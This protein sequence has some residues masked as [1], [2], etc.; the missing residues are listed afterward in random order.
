MSGIQQVVSA[1]GLGLHLILLVIGLRHQKFRTCLTFY[2]YLLAAFISTIVVHY[3][4]DERE[5][6]R[7]IYYLKEF[8]LDLIKL[9]M[10][11]DLNHRIF[12][13]FPKVRRL[14]RALF[15]TT[16]ILLLVYVIA[17][18][19][20]TKFWWGSIPFDLHSKIL[21]MTCLAYLMM[22]FSAL[23]Y[24]IDV[25]SEHKFLLMGYLLSQL[26]VALGFAYVAVAGEAARKPVSL[27]NSIFF[28][29]AL[30]VWTKVYW[31]HDKDSDSAD[32]IV[33]WVDN[34]ASSSTAK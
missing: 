10:L 12:S 4:V 29:L 16:G 27:L 24:R 7:L 33:R 25:S 22:V 30:L 6:K 14:N 15:G 18:P 11:L 23:F 8:M 32:S 34:T 21:Q 2:I 28:L 19:T 9:A 26:P 3:L 5:M 17:L 20:E 31:T 13:F 1:I